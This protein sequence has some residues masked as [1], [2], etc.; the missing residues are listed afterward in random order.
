[1]LTAARK[2]SNNRG[3]HR[4]F[5]ASMAAAI[6]VFGLAGVGTA[7]ATRA[8]SPPTS[9]ASPSDSGSAQVGDPLRDGLGRSAPQRLRIPSIGVDSRLTV[10]GLQDDNKT[11]QLPASAGQIGWYDGSPT[12]GEK[13]TSIIAGYIKDGRQ[14]G[15]LADLSGLKVGQDVTVYRKDGAAVVFTVDGI[16]KYPHGTFPADQVYAASSS[17]ALRIVTVGGTLRPGDQ[18][19][20][21]VVYTHI[22]AVHNRVASPHA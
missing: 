8:S 13:G 3:G 21:V 22:T 17:P 16:T 7:I 10:L 15:V 9:G 4:V 12:P 1:M 6:A 14:S 11:M 18:P 20:N 2:K 19:G 5:V